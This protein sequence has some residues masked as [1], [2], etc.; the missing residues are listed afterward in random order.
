M[1]TVKLGGPGHLIHTQ[2]KDDAVFGRSDPGQVI[3][4]RN[5]PPCI[6]WFHGA[7]VVCGCGR[8]EVRGV[9]DGNDARAYWWPW[10]D[11]WEDA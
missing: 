9:W 3:A 5:H 7:P 1:T 11:A 4:Y 2:G 10:S 6:T 8:Y